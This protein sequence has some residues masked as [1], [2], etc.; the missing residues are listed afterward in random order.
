MARTRRILGAVGIPLAVLASAGTASAAGVPPYLTEQG[1]LFDAMGMPISA[2]LPFVFTL[3]A[4]KDAM[5]S[6]WTETKQITLED[7]YFSTTLGDTTPIPPEAFNGTTRFLGIKVGMDPEMKPRQPLSSV[8]YSLMATNAIGDI[9]PA[10][11]AVG[12]K[13]VIDSRGRWIGDTTGLVGPTGPQGPSGPGGAQGPAGPAGPPG[14]PGAPGPGGTGGGPTGPAG[15]PGP[16]GQPGPAG[17]G[18]PPGPG[19]TGPAGPPGP[20]GP[21]GTGPAGPPGSPGPSGPAGPPGP[22]GAPGPTGILQSGAST[23]DSPAI[24]L[25][26]NSG[27][28]FL[29]SAASVDPITLTVANGDKVLVN[30]NGVVSRTGALNKI[31]V[32]FWACYQ[33]SGGGTPVIPMP[34]KTFFTTDNAPTAF[35]WFQVSHSY[36]F[37]MPAGTYT[38]GAC[39]QAAAGGD[40]LAFRYVTATAI[41]FR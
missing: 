27:V 25:A 33:P 2:A 37:T 13:V 21:G 32:N 20:T 29:A 1:R 35:S 40:A 15:P 4:D 36:I 24:N 3:Y 38:F 11:V 16:P 22:P 12:G 8:P 6:L 9:T 17:P 28:T 41:R 26:A 18:G 39:G 23:S 14:P 19:G 10:S 34:N 30:A 7:G 5:M 31:N